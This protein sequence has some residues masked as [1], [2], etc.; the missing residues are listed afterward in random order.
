MRS[1]ALSVPR[2]LLDPGLLLALALSA[3]A[4][5][6]LALKPGLPAGHDTALHAYRA[7]EM[8]RSWERGLI[9]PSW[10]EGMYFGFGSPLF[11]FYARLSYFITALL[12]IGLGVDAIDAMRWL[13]L[14]CLLGCGAGMYLFCAR[15]SGKLGA[16][17]ASMVYVYSPYLMYTETWA[18]GALPELLAF[19]LFPFLLW[20]ID[21][22]RDKP[23]PL[24][25]LLVGLLQVAL[26]NAHNLMALALT[27][28]AF[29]WL[30]FE[31][32]VQRLN[33]EASQLE[34]RDG[35]V[36]ILALLL[37]IGAA[38][39]FW[40]PVLLESES[41]RLENATDYWITDGSRSFVSLEAL[42]SPVALADAGDINGL[43]AQLNL[44]LAQWTIAALGVVS[45]LP[46]YVRGFRSW[47]PQTFLGALGF[48]IFACAL[49]IMTQPSAAP[50]W[51]AMRPLQYLQ[52]P[53]R[54]L[55]PAAACLAILASLNGLWLRR[56]PARPRAFVIALLFALPPIASIPLLYV[57]EWN[58]DSLDTSVA[59][60][61]AEEYEGRN[62]GTTSTHEYL[63]RDSERFPDSN[64]SLRQDYS[65]GYPIDKFNRAT[66]PAGA[67]AELLHN[68][69]QT[70]EWRITTDQRFVAE[71]FN[72]HWLGWRA[73]IDGQAL[74]ID[75]AANGGTISVEIPVTSG[76]SGGILR[77]Y[78]GSTPARDAAAAVSAL[79]ICCAIFAAWALTR[80]QRSARPYASA[81]PLPPFAIPG[82][83]AALCIAVICLLIGFREGVAWIKSPPGSAL[84]AQVR[85]LF[86][87][88]DTIQFIGYSLNSEAL[89]PGDRLTL[90]IW[91]YALE[92]PKLHFRSFLHL[93]REG[94]IYAQIDK[95]SPPEPGAPAWGPEGNIRDRYELRLPEELPAGDY[96]LFAG[97]YSCDLRPAGQCGG[98]YRPT[99][100]N[101]ARQIVG[102][103]VPVA[104]VRVSGG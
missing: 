10:A 45:A 50:L 29:A 33:R 104:T 77:V 65:D 22:L 64:A 82:L 12:Q 86:S 27:G 51:N 73:E 8:L 75:P 87:L 66:L 74:A 2:R 57:P 101:E 13:T 44:G 84:P 91:W 95:L 37:G 98:G 68:S 67:E 1:Y 62:M 80:R 41:A 71:I 38:A 23:G 60:L 58:I 32:L 48:A 21:A 4:I 63:P 97:L 19:A 88:D 34:A 103:S 52:F 31:T 54:L 6:P 25:F 43:S 15:R 53:W 90:D 70:L 39:T 102:N 94:K 61:H 85:R 72:L 3:F 18:R 79:A 78:L 9:F 49:I 56:L 76:D 89:R 100:R 42:L 99:V 17:L 14:L 36:A 7:A 59:A 28:L 81:M 30:L 93:S 69:P 83:V 24:N 20:R 11:H 46:L 35:G 55:G 40:L 5:I 47:H 92:R 26:I 96:E 16:I